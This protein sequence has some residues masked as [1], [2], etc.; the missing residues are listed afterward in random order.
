MKEIWKEIPSMP[1]YLA[2]NLGRIKSLRTFK[3]SHIKKKPIEVFREKI[4]KQS[5]DGKGYLRINTLY[6]TKKVHRL[7]A[8]TFLNN[9]NNYPQINHKNGKKDDNRLENLE[10]CN[11]SQNQLHAYKNGLQKRV[12]LSRRKKVYQYDLNNVFLNEYESISIAKE[13]TNISHIGSC[14]RG[15]RKT[16]GGY[17]WKFN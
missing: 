11:N 15:E 6:G 13:K 4:L 1:Y 10:Y 9:P 5:K 2:S 12:H 16:A 8:E 17:V 14:C 7:I 3:Y